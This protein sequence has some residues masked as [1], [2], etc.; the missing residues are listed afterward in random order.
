M[1]RGDAAAVAGAHDRASDPAVRE[2]GVV[3]TMDNTT[4]GAEGKR[5]IAKMFAKKPVKTE[6]D[7]VRYADGKIKWVRHDFYGTGIT[8]RGAELLT[9]KRSVACVYKGGKVLSGKWPAHAE[10]PNELRDRIARAKQGA[11]A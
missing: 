6:W 1:A 10:M 7:Q 5:T 8:R 4:V 9:E 3:Q 11:T 2:G